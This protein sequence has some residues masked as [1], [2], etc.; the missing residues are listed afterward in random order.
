MNN[1]Q[2]DEY[3]LSWLSVHGVYERQLYR[4]Y[5]NALDKQI[6]EVVKSIEEDGLETAMLL[7]P[8]T[9]NP[10]IMRLAYQKAYELV[11]VKHGKWVTDWM[12]IFEQPTKSR[13]GVHSR[14]L[15]AFGSEFWRRKM[16]D[17]LMIFGAEKVVEVDTTTINRIRRLLVQF[18]TQGLSVIDQARAMVKEL[19]NPAYNKN[20]ALTISRTETTSAAN[21]TAVEAGKEAN[22]L[23]IKE[24]L[25]IED[26]RT[27]PSHAEANGQQTDL[28]G[29]FTVGGEQLEYA[30][31]PRGSAGNIISCRC[32]TLVIPQLDEDGLPIRIR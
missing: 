3:K 12:T 17:F 29:F 26:N 2:K 7:L 22:Y 11:G 28:N 15:L 18:Q 32:S 4:I 13:Y 19:N 1:R 14:K 5:K 8:I 27:R 6:K 30:G 20:R 23:T 16:R 24:W 21:Y 25:S 9:V 31:D 10:E